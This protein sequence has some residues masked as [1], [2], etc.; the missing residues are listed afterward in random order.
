MLS[1][2]VTGACLCEIV[3]NEPSALNPSLKTEISVNF[4]CLAFQGTAS[5]V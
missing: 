2:F 3:M 5:M 1:R 4:T